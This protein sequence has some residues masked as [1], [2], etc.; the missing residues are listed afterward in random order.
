MY[1]ITAFIKNWN[2][3]ETLK[4]L[5]IETTNH[6]IIYFYNPT[7]ASVALGLPYLI[8]SITEVA[9]NTGSWTNKY[10]KSHT[11]VYNR[12]V[13]SLMDVANCNFVIYQ[14]HGKSKTHVRATCRHAHTHTY[15]PTYTHTHV[16]AHTHMH[17]RCKPL[18][19]IINTFLILIK[20]TQ[21]LSK[22]DY[23]MHDTSYGHK[24]NIQ[25]KRCVQ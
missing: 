8:F 9:N 14:I 3:Y 7:S 10:K 15:N 21:K 5:Y 23:C 19:S 24:K 22:P 6:R 2:C 17:K 11:K 20:E 4:L 13:V 1:N 18:H 25:Y 12:R 16:Y